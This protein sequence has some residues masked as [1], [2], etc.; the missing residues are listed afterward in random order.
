MTD[1]DKMYS[2]AVSMLAKN[3]E[4]ATELER[5]TAGNLTDQN[6][7]R[8]AEIRFRLRADPKNHAANYDQLDEVLT[9]IGFP[10]PLDVIP[11]PDPTAPHPY[12]GVALL[13]ELAERDRQRAQIALVEP[14]DAAERAAAI[15]ICRLNAHLDPDTGAP[16]LDPLIAQK[17]WVEDKTDLPTEKWLWMWNHCKAEWN[18]T[19]SLGGRQVRYVS[20][21]E[22]ERRARIASGLDHPLAP[23]PKP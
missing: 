9:M 15:R 10:D 18:P 2:T 20:A 4:L 8:L 21:E 5:A 1:H 14:T 13:M 23:W 16:E 7:A 22:A 12:G 17:R 19:G 11:A 3:A 6:R